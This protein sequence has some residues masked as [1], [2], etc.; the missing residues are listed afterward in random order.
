MNVFDLARRF[1]LLE[2]AG[3]AGAV[4]VVRVAA[5]GRSRACPRCD[6]RAMSWESTCENCG[7]DLTPSTNSP[8]ET[9]ALPTPEVRVTAAS[10][11]RGDDM[12]SPCEPVPARLALCVRP[13][14]FRRLARAWL[15]AHP[16]GGDLARDGVDIVCS[17]LAVPRWRDALANATFPV[18]VH[19][20]RG[21][22]SHPLPKGAALVVDTRAARRPSSV[23][24]HAVRVAPHPF[25]IARLPPSRLAAPDAVFAV[26]DVIAPGTFATP[27]EARALQRHRRDE[28]LRRRDAVL[29]RLVDPVPD[30]PARAALAPSP[31][32]AGTAW[33]L[34]VTRESP[35]PARSIVSIFANDTTVHVE[36]GRARFDALVAHTVD[37]PLRTDAIDAVVRDDAA[38]ASRAL[39]RDLARLASAYAAR[40]D[41]SPRPRRVALAEEFDVRSR[42]LLQRGRLRVSIAVVAAAAIPSDDPR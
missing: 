18:R 32:Y 14:R 33:L 27:R 37:L 28:F 19:T 5:E 2:P 40:I 29:G 31:T 38:V 22:A 6:W 16:T 42:A 12:P 23:T 1:A 36:K 13:R 21:L 4:E 7:L 11:L 39:T 34:I 25:V 41:A 15:D 9:V 24:H 26:T 8:T 30:P 35:S 17:T 3:G 10:S 20:P